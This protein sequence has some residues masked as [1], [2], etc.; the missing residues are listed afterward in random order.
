MP[1]GA[2]SVLGTSTG[3][4]DLSRSVLLWHSVQHVH[5]QVDMMGLQARRDAQT[6]SE[7]SSVAIALFAE[8]GFV[9]T[10]MA[11]VA[12]AAGVSRRTAYRHYPNKED[13]IFE[14]PRRWLEVFHGVIGSREPGEPTMD[15]CHRAVLAVAAA[16]EETKDEVL[17]GYG[18]VAANPSLRSRYAR[19]NRD[20]LD[21]YVDLIVADLDGDDATAILQASVTAGALVGGTDR[22]VIHWFLHPDSSLVSL[23]ADVLE[24]T[25]PL[26]PPQCRVA[27]VP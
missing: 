13:L 1:D 2:G 12:E 23:T 22:A 10:T 25:A 20:W 19:T 8:R 14:H 21:A 11:D 24:L 5:G 4:V 16:I 3:F 27:P 17:P 15:L 9:E 18:V 26:W 6:R 7:L